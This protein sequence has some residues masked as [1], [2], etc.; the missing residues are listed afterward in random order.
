MD[1][2]KVPVLV[3]AF[4]GV[5]AIFVTVGSILIL[6]GGRF[7]HKI[8]EKSRPRRWV[9]AIFISYFVTFCL[10]FPAWSF[11]P[12]TIISRVLS[13]LF[14]AFTT[15]IGGW[16]VLGRVGA[17]LLPIIVLFERIVDSFKDGSET[18]RR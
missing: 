1:P 4:L 7:Y 13:L 10:W 12:R 6:S 16:C 8:P 17:I 11:Y 3:V 18:G 9:V 2:Y 14:A 15:F 5:L